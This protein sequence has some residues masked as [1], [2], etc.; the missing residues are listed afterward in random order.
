VFK[1]VSNNCLINRKRIKDYLFL[2]IKT[3]WSVSSCFRIR[4]NYIRRKI[5]PFAIERKKFYFL[6]HFSHI[7]AFIFFIEFTQNWFRF[8]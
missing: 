1:N 3:Y 6:S 7:N 5:I 4:P 8:L 2:S